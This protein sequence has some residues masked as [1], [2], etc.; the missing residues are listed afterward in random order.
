VVAP[1]LHRLHHPRQPLA[2]VVDAPR[3]GSVGVVEDGSD[4]V[5]EAPVAKPPRW[6]SRPRPDAVADP[7][8]RFETTWADSTSKSLRRSA[9]ARSHVGLS[10]CVES[11][12]HPYYWMARLSAQAAEPGG[13]VNAVDE[14]VKE[15]HASPIV[16]GG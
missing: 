13:F 15:V 14:D 2:P 11:G 1:E 7:R 6:A 9:V 16:A 12:S 10:A 4:D 8:Q 3:H 5:V